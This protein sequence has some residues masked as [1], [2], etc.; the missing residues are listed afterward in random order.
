MKTRLSRRGFVKGLASAPA[1]AALPSFAAGDKLPSLWVNLDAAQVKTTGDTLVA[2]TGLV[3]RT[4]TWTGK[5]LV[6]T[7][8]RNVKS[9]RQWAT[10]KPAFGADW[11][12]EGLIDESGAARLK[13]LTARPVRFDP[14]TSSHIE[15]IAELE[16]PGSRIAFQYVIGVY[17]NS[18]GIRTQLR[19][20]G[21]SGF[22]GSGVAKQESPRLDYVPVAFGSS[23]RRAIGYYNHTQR[24]NT[25]E[26]EILREQVRADALSGREVCDW[27]GILCVE[28]GREGFCLV[29][30]SHK[31]VNQPG[32]NTGDF[33]CD[34][35]GLSNTGW[36]PAPSDILTKRFRSCWA[37]WAIAYDGGDDGRELAIKT[38]DR[39]RYPVDPDRDI[40][41]MAN[42]WGSGAAKAESLEASREENILLQIESCRDLGIDVQQIDDGWQGN[43]YKT[44]SPVKHR[45]PDGWKNVRAA[46]AEAG[47]KLGLWAS[48]VIG[49]EA[50]RKTRD[51]GGF[52]YYKIDFANLGTY[53]RLESLIEKMRELIRHSGHT[54]RVNWDVTENPAR[55]G[56]YF[57]RDLGN[58]YLENRKPFQPAQVV[59][60][61]YLVLRDAWQVARYTNLNRFQVT[62]QNIERVNPEVSNARL[63][64]HP[65]C[66]A[67]TLMGSPI[68]FQ[69]TTYYTEEA[70]NR[71]R[72]LLALYKKHRERMYRGY[73]F[74][75]GHKPDDA[76]WTGFQ[77]H[78]PATGA[79]YL[80]IFRELRAPEYKKAL[81]L[82]FVADSM[83]RLTDLAS[84]SERTVTVPPDGKVWFEIA[85]S[86][87][88]QF[89]RYEPA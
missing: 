46:A 83:I 78:D 66:V 84:N 12:Y 57:A 17:P 48:W 19:V 36:G 24:R 56:Y 28:D 6:T 41:I 7:G 11:G 23:A 88:F 2:S 82:R 64:N 20:K 67:I 35:R 10:L 5:G 70:R 40:Y 50:L 27:A 32:V 15:V 79:G 4:W 38:F 43:Q 34:S 8:L 47:V 72:P 62:V 25:R 71:I 26:T 33:Q 65:Y 85:S 29:K 54:A 45:Y 74:G 13:S 73:V 55:V 18:P 69:E 61:P 60:V 68:F 63:H 52:N 59:Y 9:E 87:G 39:R 75:I 14:F 86:P 42:T 31:C 30:E 49:P 3:E 51:D 80:M 77:N 22:S 53:D 44:W 81:P 58:I 76:S 37:S 16:Y 89:L 21:L 1:A